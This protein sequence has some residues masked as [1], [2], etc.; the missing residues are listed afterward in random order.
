[1]RKRTLAATSFYDCPLVSRS[2]RVRSLLPA[3]PRYRRPAVE[4]LDAFEGSS[5]HYWAT[6]L[7]GKLCA[8]QEI[9]LVGAGNSAGQAAVYL[10]GQSAKVWMLERIPVM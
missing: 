6:P 7:E 10:A 5:V 2:E 1:V 3:A 4:T 9:A 8:N